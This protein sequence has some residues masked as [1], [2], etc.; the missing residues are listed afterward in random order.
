MQ[1]EIETDEENG[2]YKVFMVSLCSVAV[3]VAAVVKL[4]IWSQLVI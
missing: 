4:F 1:L 3:A 2:D